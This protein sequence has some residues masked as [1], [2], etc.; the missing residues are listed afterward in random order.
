MVGSF[1]LAAGDCIRHRTLGVVSYQPSITE[2]YWDE[3]PVRDDSFKLRSVSVEKCAMDV[4]LDEKRKYWE[5]V[6]KIY[7]RIYARA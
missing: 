2:Q 3:I 4:T 6:N 1:V 7:D 5:K